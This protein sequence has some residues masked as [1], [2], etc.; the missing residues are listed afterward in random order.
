MDYMA[1]T[2]HAYKAHTTS[3]I[4]LKHDSNARSNHS[5]IFAP[6]E[7]ESQSQ[8][9]AALPGIPH[10]HIT[11]IPR[12]HD[13]GKSQSTYH[14]TEI[15]YHVTTTPQCRSH[16]GNLTENHRIKHREQSSGRKTGWPRRLSDAAPV[17][18]Q[19]ITETWNSAL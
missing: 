15:T 5:E 16:T 10:Y 19:T 13:A 1:H 14:D 6:H 7:R 12:Y 17:S 4:A 9:D 3:L 2:A 11:G 8:R 18:A